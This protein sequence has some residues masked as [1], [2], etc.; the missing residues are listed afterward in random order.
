MARDWHAW[1][2]E[3]DDPGSELSRR[4]AV[5]RSEL[6]DVLADR[7]G[8]VTLLSL[9]A[10]DGRDTLPELASSAS[11]VTAVLVELDPDLAGAGHA[12]RRLSASRWTCAPTTP[13]WSRRGW[14]SYRSTCSCSAASSATS[15]TTT[16]GAS[17]PARR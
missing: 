12:R 10:G 17:S 14:T 4:L 9:C 8:P 15:P 2:G 11:P 6:A 7:T 5:V 1:Y 13:V 16:P 3:Y